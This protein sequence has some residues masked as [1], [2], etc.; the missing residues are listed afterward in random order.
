MTRIKRGI[1]FVCA[2]A[3]AVFSAGCGEEDF[4]NEPRPPVPIELTGVIQ[5]DEVTVSPDGRGRRKVGAGPILITISNQTDNAHTVILEGVGGAR[6]RVQVGPIQPLDT[7][8][9]Q[10]TLR[11]G[12]YEVRAGSEVAQRREIEPA[13]LVVGAPRKPSNDELLLP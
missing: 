3:I 10:K 9:I 13:V 2:G 7:A 12:R 1:A 5:E 4:P 11:R 6:T 8:T